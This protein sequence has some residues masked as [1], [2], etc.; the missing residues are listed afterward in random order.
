[1]TFIIGGDFKARIGLEEQ[2]FES[3]CVSFCTYAGRS[4]KDIIINQRGH[5][6]LDFMSQHNLIVLNGRTKSDRN[7]NFTFAADSGRSTID[8][9]FISIEDVEKCDDLMVLEMHYSDH[10]RVQVSIKP[11]VMSNRKMRNEKS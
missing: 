7:G 2:N 1:M 10:F 9:V 5:A 3:D 4:A 11:S 6:L 8:L